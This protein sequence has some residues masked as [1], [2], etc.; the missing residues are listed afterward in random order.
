LR[1]QLAEQHA[2]RGTVWLVHH[3]PWG[4]DAYSTLHSQAD[5]CASGIV[6]FLRDDTSGELFALLRQYAGTISASFSAH[7]HYDDFRLLMDHS[8]KPVL[9]DKMVP[10][11]SPI[12]GQ[13]PGS[14]SSPTTSPVARLWTTQ[15]ITWPIS[16]CCR[17]QS[18][19]TGG[20]DMYSRS[21]MVRADIR[22]RPSVRCRVNWTNRAWLVNSTTTGGQRCRRREITVPTPVRSLMSNW[23]ATHAAIVGLCR[24]QERPT[25]PAPATSYVASRCSALPLVKQLGPDAGPGYPVQR[26]CRLARSLS[27]KLLDA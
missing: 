11:I 12:F 18:R 21:Y 9:I 10:A 22:R 19:E 8:G 16:T 2:R 7:T 20:S 5:R 26:I 17:R 1:S 13:D 25:W 23:R 6:S 14:R 24:D 27:P 15:A 3:I 4:I